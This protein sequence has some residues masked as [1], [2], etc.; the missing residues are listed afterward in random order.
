VDVDQAVAV[1]PAQAHIEGLQ[2]TQRQR[3][4]LTHML[5][6]MT[7]VLG[8]SCL[9]PA[10]T[11]CL[12]CACPRPV[13][14]NVSA[15]ASMQCQGRLQRTHDVMQAT[16]VQRGWHACQAHSCVAV[17]HLVCLLMHNLVRAACWRVDVVPQHL[18]GS[19]QVV[20]HGVELHT[21]T[22]EYCDQDREKAIKTGVLQS[23]QGEAPRATF[24]GALLVQ[25]VRPAGLPRLQLRGRHVQTR[26]HLHCK[27]QHSMIC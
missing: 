27:V 18:V 20:L 5:E 4:Q 9:K 22:H 11:L 19:I 15:P 26:A 13:S 2:A 12:T 24:A 8:S 14:S 3:L 25:V 7:A 1:A 17:C 16:L 10:I 21:G 6:T 23:R